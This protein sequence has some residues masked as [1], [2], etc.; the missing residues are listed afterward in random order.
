M[1]V[2]GGAAAGGVAVVAGVA[3]AGG[4]ALVGVAPVGG[5]AAWPFWASTM[6]SA[7]DPVE[8]CRNTTF[9]GAIHDGSPGDRGSAN[10]VPEENEK[11]LVVR[12]GG[13]ASCGEARTGEAKKSGTAVA[14]A[15]DL[16]DCF[17]PRN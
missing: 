10:G 15:D 16:A 2:D 5:V 17:L 1:A 7:G 13:S 6:V 9:T 12:G 11:L 3:A 4:V 8:V 14:M